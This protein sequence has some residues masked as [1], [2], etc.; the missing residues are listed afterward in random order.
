[1]KSSLPENFEAHNKQQTEYYDLSKR[2]AMVPRNSPYLQ[3]HVDE[4]IRLA[5]IGPGDRVLE[6]GCGMGRN[7]FI[8]AQRGIR[9]EGLDLIQSLLDR[10]RAIDGGEYNIPLYCCD[11]LEYP[12]E[13]TESFDA[14]IG[15]FA[16]H[17]MHDLQACYQAM[18]EM[19]KPGGRIVFLE[20]NPLNPLYY[21]QILVTPTMS[22]QG[23]RGLKNMRKPVLFQAMK[24]AGLQTCQLERFGFFPP[25]VTNHAVGRRVE[26]VLERFPLWRPFLPFQLF[27]AQKPA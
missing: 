22:W 15:F 6:V 17:H 12:R 11:V 18:S 2:Q 25:F 7:T 14:V 3:R 1:M 19:L 23:E 4:V 13:L 5:E 24:S 16:L 20:P 10:M 9:I 21:L 27:K 26:A 8:L